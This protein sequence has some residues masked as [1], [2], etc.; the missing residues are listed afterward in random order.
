MNVITIATLSLM[1]LSSVNPWSF[2]FSLKLAKNNLHDQDQLE[3]AYLLCKMIRQRY[4]NEADDFDFSAAQI[5]EYIRRNRVNTMITESDKGLFPLRYAVR[6]G[7]RDVVNLLLKHGSDPLGRDNDGVVIDEVLHSSKAGNILLLIDLLSCVHILDTTLMSLKQRKLSIEYLL[8]RTRSV[9]SL[10]RNRLDDLKLPRLNALKYRVVGQS[11]AIEQIISEIASHFTNT[12]LSNK[13]L[14]LLFAG[15]P[16]HGK[17]ETAKQIADLL[18]AP[19]HKVDCRNHA[20]PWEMFGSGAGYVGSD[21]ASQ[22]ASFI[23]ANSGSNSDPEKRNVV[24]L[25]EFDHCEPGTWEAFYHIFE[26]GEFTLK[27]ISAREQSQTTVLDCSSTIWLLTTNKFDNDIVSFSEKFSSAI[28]SYKRGDYPFENL[29]NKF[30]DFIRPKMRNLFQGGLTRRINAVVPFFCFD[31]TEAYVITDIYIDSLRDMY[32]KPPNK[33]RKV[34]NVHFDVSNFAIGELSR[35][36]MRH[37]LDGAS[38]IVRE[39]NNKLVKKILHMNWLESDSENAVSSLLAT[40]SARSPVWIHCSDIA[41]GESEDWS[42][43]GFYMVDAITEAQLEMKPYFMDR[44]SSSSSSSGAG[45][46]PAPRNKRI[47]P[48]SFNQTSNSSFDFYEKHRSSE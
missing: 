45:F 4:Q 21:S 6:L 12:E 46:E 15:P 8:A 39:V 16:G 48:D 19:F 5:N 24:L 18:D 44:G 11:F 23:E 14:V 17:S 7:R 10:P 20:N 43:K 42:G 30:E 41:S 28:E 31:E 26:E 13:P 37:K 3:K 29:N 47:S 33:K 36:Y 9:K 22:L 2:Q 34:G 38:A 1:Y 40:S 32:Q 25:D 35:N 27:K